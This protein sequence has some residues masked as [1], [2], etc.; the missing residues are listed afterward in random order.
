MNQ[1]GDVDVKTINQ[2]ENS[3]LKNGPVADGPNPNQSVECQS[4]KYPYILLGK[5][6]TG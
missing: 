5:Q 1:V 3:E 6:A 4:W 2:M